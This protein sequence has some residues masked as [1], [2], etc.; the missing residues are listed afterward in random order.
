MHDVTEEDVL[1]ERKRLAIGY[2][3]VLAGIV[4][5]LVA[6]VLVH[7]AESPEVDDL[8][9]E[10]YSA[11]PRGWVIVTIA[12]TVAIGGFLVIMAG[13]WFAHIHLRKLTW[14]TAMLG[15]LLF[16][17]LMLIIFAIIPNQW[18]T[19]AQS[20]LE[21]TPQKTFVT[22]PSFLVL[23]SEISISFAAL[24]DM[25]LQGYV[26]TMLLG[27]PVAMYQI[28][29]RSKKAKDAPPPTPVSDYG[30]PLRVDRAATNGASTNGS[31]V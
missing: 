7:M 24:K 6:S 18:L 10:L 9:R 30:R 31:G 5:T 11:I 13:I 26:I 1:N 16:S 23:G 20:T 19:L 17:G 3:A 21:W 25:L 22:I 28:Q 12:Q 27:V 14:A 2:L 4:V 8:G 29:E 15:A